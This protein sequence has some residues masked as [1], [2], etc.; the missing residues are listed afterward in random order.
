MRITTGEASTFTRFWNAISIIRVVVFTVG[1]DR[2]RAVAK[3]VF[4][5]TVWAFIRILRTG[6]G[7]PIKI[8]IRCTLLARSRCLLV[9]I[10]PV[11]NRINNLNKATLPVSVKHM[12]VIRM[13]VRVTRERL[14]A[15]QML[16][17]LASERL[18]RKEDSN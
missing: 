8:L 13:I 2:W 1:T 16:P 12:Q 11:A 17:A 3:N 15:L 9:I 10:A 18:G 4:S 5:L 6:I 14:I 7:V